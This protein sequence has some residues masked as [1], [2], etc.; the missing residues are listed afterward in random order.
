MDMLSGILRALGV[1]L[2]TPTASVPAL[3]SLTAI[4]LSIL[5]FVRSVRA[6]ALPRLEAKSSYDLAPRTWTDIDGEPVDFQALSLKVTNRA[7]GTAYDVR[8]RVLDCDDEGARELGALGPDESAKASFNLADNVPWPGKF[9]LS[10]WEYPKKRKLVKLI[11]YGE[12]VSEGFH[13]FD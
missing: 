3:L 9:E 12:G 8:V 4:V 6:V 7:N 10:W 11:S 2:A 1:F 5:N 13:N